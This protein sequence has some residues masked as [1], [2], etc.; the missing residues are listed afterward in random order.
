[1]SLPASSHKWLDTL[2][3]PVRLL[4]LIYRDVRCQW[5]NRHTW[6]HSCR[7][8]FGDNGP[9]PRYWEY[10]D[11]CTNPYCRAVRLGSTRH[12]RWR[13]EHGMGGRPRMI[14]EESEE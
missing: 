3:I 6:Y 4:I 7:L 10:E 12:V 13:P 8:I 14:S 9:F 2:L 5:F 11:V 1:M